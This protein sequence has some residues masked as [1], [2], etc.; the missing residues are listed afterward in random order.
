MHAL[1]SVGRPKPQPSYGWEAEAW[2]GE[3][4]EAVQQVAEVT[5]AGRVVG[6]WARAKVEGGLVAAAAG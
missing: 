6:A 4:P 2:D 3:G 5:G 1:K